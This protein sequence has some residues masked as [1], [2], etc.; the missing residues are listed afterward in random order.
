L[1]TGHP[2]DYCAAFDALI[3]GQATCLF[4]RPEAIAIK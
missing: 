2:G 3:I 1:V 4:G